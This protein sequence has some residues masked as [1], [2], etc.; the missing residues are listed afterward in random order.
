MGYRIEQ[1]VVQFGA[2]IR[3]W[4]MV[5]NLTAKQVSDRAGIGRDTLR[6]LENGD[7][8][9]GLGTTMQV[10]RALGQLDALVAAID[11]LN[12]DIGRARAHLIHRRRTATTAR[13]R[14]PATTPAK[15]PPAPLADTDSSSLASSSTPTGEQSHPG[16]PRPPSDRP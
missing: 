11:P 6:R 10:L 9:V 8:A 5:L 3:Q 7:P 1:Q 15:A 16:A 14:R 13:H 2:F 12:S 4:R